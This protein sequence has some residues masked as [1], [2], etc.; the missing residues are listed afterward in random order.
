MDYYNTNPNTNP[1]IQ[2]SGYPMRGTNAPLSS[3]NYTL[4]SGNITDYKKFPSNYPSMWKKL[5]R[6]L[7]A[8]EIATVQDALYV[9]IRTA[10]LQYVYD[11]DSTGTPQAYDIYFDNVFFILINLSNLIENNLITIHR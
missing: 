2:Q 1:Q 9:R 3:D 4:Y 11:F 10:R 6:D 7:D 8:W 5:V